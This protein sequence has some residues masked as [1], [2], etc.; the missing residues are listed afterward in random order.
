MLKVSLSEL[1]SPCRVLAIG[2]HSDDI[3]IG[4]GGTLLTLIESLPSVEVRWVVLSALGDRQA[5]ARRS[6]AASMNS[7]KPF[8]G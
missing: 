1:P 2:C 7:R 3:E 8:D 5:E 6:A 4:C